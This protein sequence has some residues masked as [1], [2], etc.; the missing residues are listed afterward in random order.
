MSDIRSIVKNHALNRDQGC[1]EAVGAGVQIGG[2]RPDPHHVQSQGSLASRCFGE[3]RPSVWGQSL[4]G[5]PGSGGEETPPRVKML[6]VQLWHVEPM[7]GNK[8]W[9]VGAGQDSLSLIPK[10]G[11]RM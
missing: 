8:S 11:T 6:Q 5:V 1:Q 9:E 3:A 4:P 10:R 2:R 7:G